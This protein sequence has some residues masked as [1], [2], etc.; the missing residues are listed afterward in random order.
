VKETI[1]FNMPLDQVVPDE[2]WK[3]VQEFVVTPELNQRFMDCLEDHFP[4]YSDDSPYGGTIAEPG[5]LHEMAFMAMM[6]RFPV[7]PPA[8]KQSVHAKQESQ[9][10]YPAKVGTKV[11]IEVRL[12]EKYVKRG[13]DYI[14]HEARLTDEG[15]RILLISRHFRMI[16]ERG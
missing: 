3:L 15:G 2:H 13:K 14:L 7:A 1:E 11:K 8:G 12:T 6:R 10:Y 5:M 4:W 16:G 9:L